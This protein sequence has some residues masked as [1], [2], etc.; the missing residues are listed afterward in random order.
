MR[1]NDAV[2]YRVWRILAQRKL[3]LIRVPPLKGFPC[4]RAGGRFHG[5][6]AFSAACAGVTG[7]PNGKYIFDDSASRRRT[8]RLMPAGQCQARALAATGVARALAHAGVKG[9]QPKTGGLWVSR[10][11]S[12]LSPCNGCADLCNRLDP[13]S[14]PW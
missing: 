5:L 11:G 10:R 4:R 1:K 2:S 3:I 6:T 12:W 7:S 8:F 14:R 13:T 9:K